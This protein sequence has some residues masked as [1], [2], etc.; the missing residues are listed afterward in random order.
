MSEEKKKVNFLQVI[1]F[2]FCVCLGFFLGYY[3]MTDV[4]I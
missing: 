3:L 4:F 2:M 1:V